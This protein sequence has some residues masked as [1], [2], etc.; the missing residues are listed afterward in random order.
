MPE[1]FELRILVEGA[2][3]CQ[4]ALDG[5]LELGRQKSGEPGPYQVLPA[6]G[7]APLTDMRGSAPRLPLATQ[8]RNFNTRASG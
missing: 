5:P 6:G 1:T 4:V 2:V 7:P 3:A 8:T